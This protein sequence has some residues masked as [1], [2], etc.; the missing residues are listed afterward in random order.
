MLLKMKQEA[1][2]KALRRLF[3]QMVEKFDKFLHRISSESNCGKVISS[4]KL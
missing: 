4:L 3:D 2:M 1:I